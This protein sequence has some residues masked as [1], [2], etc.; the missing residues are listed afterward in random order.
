MMDQ[1]AFRRVQR[2]GAGVLGVILLSAGV[3]ILVS[4]IDPLALC[5][6]RCGLETLLSTVIGH[7]TLRTLIGAFS[8]GLGILF[9]LGHRIRPD[10]SRK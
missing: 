10:R 6:K 3:G 9:L 2:W 4:G 8:T 7:S 5:T 1:N